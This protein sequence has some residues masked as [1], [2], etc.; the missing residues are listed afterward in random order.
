MPDV[1]CQKET[2]E[3]SHDAFTKVGDQPQVVELNEVRRPRLEK[4]LQDNG[5]S[6]CPSLYK[7]YFQLVTKGAK[8]SKKRFLLGLGLI[9]NKTPRRKGRKLKAN[10][11]DIKKQSQ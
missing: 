7:M 3:S 1:E 8:N 2:K 5:D 6:P 11:N 4:L 10:E 9:S